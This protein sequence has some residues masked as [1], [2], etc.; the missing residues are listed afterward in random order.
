MFCLNTLAV[1]FMIRNNSWQV[2][3]KQ[4]SRFS[5]SVDFT[6]PIYYRYIYIYIEIYISTFRCSFRDVHKN[7]VYWNLEIYL[8]PNQFLYHGTQTLNL[9]QQ[10]NKGLNKQLPFSSFN[11]SFS[12]S[13]FVKFHSKVVLIMYYQELKKPKSCRFI[14]YRMSHNC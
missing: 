10:M 3:K 1:Q 6:S 14:A 11:N 12:F 7:I 13:R 5:T 2:V 8:L 4:T 9:F